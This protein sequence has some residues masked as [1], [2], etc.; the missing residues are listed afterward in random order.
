MT[1]NTKEYQRAYYVAHREERKAY[2]RE[3]NK[4]KKLEK[5]TNPKLFDMRED[6][7]TSIREEFKEVPQGELTYSQKYYAANK[8]RIRAQQK[9][10]RE[11]KR[12]VEKRRAYYIEHR[13][14]L[15]EMQRKNYAKKK[16]RERLSKTFM[17]RLY[18]KVFG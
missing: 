15:C 3:Y 5:Q 1:T 13:E 2:Y 12:A 14:H 18:L 9:I 8:E 7:K 11:K 16:K 4:R 6:Y 10:A 17:G